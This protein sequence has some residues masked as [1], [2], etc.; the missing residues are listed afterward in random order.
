MLRAVCSSGKKDNAL[1]VKRIDQMFT[2]AVQKEFQLTQCDPRRNRCVS[3]P[4]IPFQTVFYLG[5]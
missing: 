4:R 3:P 2:D 5:V 1:G